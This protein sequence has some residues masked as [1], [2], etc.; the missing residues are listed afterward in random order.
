[1]PVSR[2]RLM[3]AYKGY[4][5]DAIPVA[6]LHQGILPVFPAEIEPQ[7][8]CEVRLR[9]LQGPIPHRAHIQPSLA[10]PSHRHTIR[11]DRQILPL[12][13][14]PSSRKALAAF[15][16]QQVLAI[17]VQAFAASMSKTF[18]VIEKKTIEIL[19]KTRQKGG[20]DGG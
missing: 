9:R 10:V 15:F 2:P 19:P 1:M 18:E 16:C 11:Q 3:L 8:D 6:L 5:G 17:T 4:N 13:P 20:L 14:M 7:I 12:L